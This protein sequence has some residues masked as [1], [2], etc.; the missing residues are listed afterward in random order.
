MK[1]NGGHERSLQQLVALLR[2][3]SDFATVN[4]ATVDRWTRGTG[5][6][7]RIRRALDHLERVTAGSPPVRI[8]ALHPAAEGLPFWFLEPAALGTT[9]SVWAKHDRGEPYKIGDRHHLNA[10]MRWFATGG[11]ALHALERGEV[12]IAIAS[13]AYAELRL[14]V[15]SVKRLCSI[16]E[17]PLSA[18]TQNELQGAWMLGNVVIGVQAATALRHLVEKHLKAMNVRGAIIREFEPGENPAELFRSGAVGAIVGTPRWLQEL[19]AELQNM[20]L[21]PYFQPYA[22]FFGHTEIDLFL[23]LDTINPATVR[24]L[25]AALKDAI[26]LIDTQKDSMSFQRTVKALMGISTLKEVA[27]ILSAYTFCLDKLDVD[28]TLQ[29]WT[30][31]IRRRAEDSG[32]SKRPKSIGGRQL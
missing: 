6:P 19:Y 9:S 2:L 4:R 17:L 5:D 18:I 14:K 29:L 22:P 20:M 31:E 8:G 25:L 26:T 30:S 21:T 3:D 12:D 1:S 15:K 24:T 23:R 10:G 13:K 7:V 16:C 27:G 11:A 32:S 28:T